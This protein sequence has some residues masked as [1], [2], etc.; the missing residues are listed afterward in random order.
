MV[1]QPAM[2]LGVGHSPINNAI[3]HTLEMQRKQAFHLI[4]RRVVAHEKYS[5]I[6][7]Y[8]MWPILYKTSPTEDVKN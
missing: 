5:V 8:C 6:T 4:A 1:M 3:T 2:S 7:N